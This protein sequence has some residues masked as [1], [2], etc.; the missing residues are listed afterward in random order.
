MN[1]NSVSIVWFSQE[2]LFNIRIID[3][4]CR[5]ID[6]EEGEDGPLY[7]D[8]TVDHPL[9]TEAVDAAL[10]LCDPEHG[11]PLHVK[12]VLEWDP[13]S[14]EKYVSNTGLILRKPIGSESYHFFF[15]SAIEQLLM[16][17]M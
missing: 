7:L 4:V 3:G 14:K 10:S 15:F 1:N 5:F 16:T 11:T 13:D 17:K 8:A 12:I 2:P 6:S 9:Y